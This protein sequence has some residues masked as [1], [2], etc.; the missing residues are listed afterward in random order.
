[1]KAVLFD[2]DGTLLDSFESNL[3]YFQRV[4]SNA[5]Y[6]QPTR[7]AYRPHMHLSTPDY[8]RLHTST[9]DEAELERIMHI[10]KTIQYEEEHPALLA[11]DAVWAIENLKREYAL[12][13]VTNRSTLFMFE[14][15]LDS[16]RTYFDVMVG[17]EDVA[18]PKPDPEP[19]LKA[20]S[21]LGLP[22]H[23]CTYVGDTLAD[24]TAAKAAGM[25]IILYGDASIPGADRYLALFSELPE[26]LRTL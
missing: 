8:I 14:G 2:I 26:L 3:E 20:A 6:A 15:P 13:L 5:G 10:A 25:K 1:M 21:L 18:R 4:F 9:T 7:E 12:G 22:P 17:F 19:L 11:R 16:L 23:E 24:V